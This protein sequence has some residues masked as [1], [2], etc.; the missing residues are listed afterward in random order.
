MS[1][2]RSDCTHKILELMMMMEIKSESSEKIAKND[3]IPGL[4]MGHFS[5]LSGGESNVPSFELA[6]E[7]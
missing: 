1:V 7:D 2:S 3:G 6:Q 5:S 4:M